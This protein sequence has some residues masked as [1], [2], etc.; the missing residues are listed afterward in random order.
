MLL[1]RGHFTISAH[2]GIVYIH[3]VRNSSI[4]ISC[5]SA[6]KEETPFAFSLKRRMLQSTRVLYLSKGYTPFINKSEFKDRITVRDEWDNHTVHLTISNLQGQDTDVYHCEFHYGD[7]PYDKNIPGKME[8]FIYVED[9]CRWLLF[10]FIQIW[11]YMKLS[12]SRSM[13]ILP[14]N[15]VEIQNTL[16]LHSVYHQLNKPKSYRSTSFSTVNI[17]FHAVCYFWMQM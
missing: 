15:P 9:F 4:D 10:I 6:N 13:V 2:G 7:L 12:R 17:D 14:P 8:F 3:R 1:T 11:V 5:E 16:I